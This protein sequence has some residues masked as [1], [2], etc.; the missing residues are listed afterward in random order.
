MKNTVLN[1]YLTKLLDYLLLHLHY[2]TR[3]QTNSNIKFDLENRIISG[4]FN[5]NLINDE[6]NKTITI[7]NGWF[8]ITG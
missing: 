4:A 7:T 5:L 2:E 6:T 1:N 3:I 8:D